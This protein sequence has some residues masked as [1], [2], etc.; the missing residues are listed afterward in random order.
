[1]HPS[2]CLALLNQLLTVNAPARQLVLGCQAFP[3]VLSALHRQTAGVNAHVGRIADLCSLLA[4]T[5]DGRLYLLQTHIASS[6]TT[7]CA[8]VIELEVQQR[9]SDIVKQAKGVD[10][11]CIHPSTRSLLLAHQQLSGLL[12]G[13]SSAASKQIISLLQAAID[14]TEGVTK[15]VITD[16]LLSLMSCSAGLAHLMAVETKAAQC[17]QWMLPRFV[18]GK[19]VRCRGSSTFLGLLVECRLAAMLGMAMGSFSPNAWRRYMA[20]LC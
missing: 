10:P 13:Q 17:L 6:T 15:N 20:W 1:M 19:Q 16:H 12:L 7:T 4:T 5:H 8:N 14:L 11:I 2:G 9:L 3:L 18:Q